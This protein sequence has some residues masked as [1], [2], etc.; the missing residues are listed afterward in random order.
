MNLITDVKKLGAAIESIGRR[1]AKLDAD[2]QLAALSSINRIELH[3]DVGYLNRLYLA[4]PKGS[5][6]SALVEW[7]LAFGKVAANTDPATKK[8][9][10]FLFAKDKT[11]NLAGADAKPWFTFKPEKAPDEVF[12]LQAAIA[13]LLRKASNKALKEGQTDM[14]QKLKALH[15][16]APVPK[17]PAASEQDFGYATEPVT[18]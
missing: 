18:A 14:L 7:A 9:Q 1:G 3:G 17:E 2:I 16:S 8:E 12:D 15:A 11:T 4:M 5:R 10:P 6:S 13:T